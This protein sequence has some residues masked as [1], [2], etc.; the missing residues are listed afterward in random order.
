MGAKTVRE[1]PGKGSNQH[2]Q[3]VIPKTSVMTLILSFLQILVPA[4]DKFDQIEIL[5]G[6]I[7]LSSQATVS[8]GKKPYL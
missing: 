5:S 1:K 6:Y 8:D 4:H 2:L 7:Y 3:E